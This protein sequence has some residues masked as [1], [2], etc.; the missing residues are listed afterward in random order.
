MTKHIAGCIA[1]LIMLGGCANSREAGSPGPL[2]EGAT[3]EE[4][5]LQLVDQARWAMSAHNMQPWEIG[6]DP[7]DPQLLRVFLARDRLLPAPDPFSRHILMSVGGFLALFG[8]G[9]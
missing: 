3:P 2:A 9:G 8:G 5:R 1:L 4:I 6:L 7:A